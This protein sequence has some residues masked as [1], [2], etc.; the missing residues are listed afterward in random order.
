MPNYS[1]ENF[2]P[3]NPDLTVWRYI[4]FEKFESLLKTKSLFFCRSDLFVDPF[5]GSIPK[6]EAEHRF[7]EA[8]RNASHPTAFELEQ[9]ATLSIEPIKTL[10]K[11]VKRAFV[12]NCWHINLTESDAMWR[13]Y[14]KTNKGVAIQSTTSRLNDVIEIA[15]EDIAL[16]KVRYI[17]YETD[18]WFDPV[19]Y[20][21]KNYNLFSPLIHKRIEFK[22]EAEVRLLHL[23]EAAID[24]DSFWNNQSDS[25]GKFIQ[26]DI[27]RL[28]ENIYLPPTFDHEFEKK[29]KELIISHGYDFDVK[30]SK[31]LLDPVF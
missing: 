5:E 10:H 17:D 30:R 15:N 21:H 8:K 1:H 27:R 2:I 22:H 9:R 23:I 14:V 18:I 28:I 11:N 4:D 26:I 19:E 20:P 12:V 16:S 3:V 25:N 29:I 7:E 6:K 13:L 31:L 24:D